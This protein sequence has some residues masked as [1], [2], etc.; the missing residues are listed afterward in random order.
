MEEL[1]CISRGAATDMKCQNQ[2]AASSYCCPNP[3]PFGILFHFGHQF[4]QLQMP[5]G[6][7]PLKQPLVKPFTMMT[8]AL[9]P[10]GDGGVMVTKDAASSRNI[11]PF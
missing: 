4:I 10:T 11:N 9:Y 2:L 6:Q 1:V 3:N 7:R 8:T 5:N